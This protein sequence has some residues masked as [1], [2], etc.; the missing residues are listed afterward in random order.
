MLVECHHCGAPLDIRGSERFAKCKYCDHTNLV[1]S[2]KTVATQT[3]AQ[4]QPPQI[5]VPPAHLANH[6]KQVQVQLRYHEVTAVNLAD[7]AQAAKTASKVGC[8]VAAS[9]MVVVAVIAGAAV[10]AAMPSSIDDDQTPQFGAHSVAGSGRLDF[11][12]SAMGDVSAFNVGSSCRG[13]VSE[14][15]QLVLDVRQPMQ[16]RIDARGTGE[17]DAT[18]MMRGADGSI[19]CDDDSGG[20]RA[21]RI[22]T[23]VPPGRYRVWAGM[24]SMNSAEPYTLSVV[25]GAVQALPDARGVVA[26]GPPTGGTVDLATMPGGGRIE[27][28]TQPGVMV[29][30]WGSGCVGYVPVVPHL[31]VQAREPTPVAISAH[32]DGPGDLVLVVQDPQGTLHCNDDTDGRHPA[33]TFVAPPGVTAIWVGLLTQSHAQEQ[34][35]LEARSESLGGAARLANGLAPDAPPQM[36]VVEVR[37]NFAGVTMPGETRGTIRGQSVHGRC[38]GYFPAVPHVALQVG[39]RQR[40]RL[41]TSGTTDD[42]TMLVR[43]PGGDIRCDDDGGGGSQ[44]RLDLSLGPGAHH[45]WI[46]RYNEGAT[47][48]FSLRVLPR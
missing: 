6:F 16:L 19:R 40:V 47:V 38:R 22:D 3:P 36:G 17:G 39:R 8:I 14:A 41:E 20:D 5:W 7:A 28:T 25:Y 27:G 15:P 29:N 13:Y 2:M 21:A 35:T 23:A 43:D 31:H 33:V 4:W 30:T 46:G 34:F 45:V 48:S 26:A 12:G 32:T 11:V 37:R 9:V 44:P 10:Y 42:L 1:R 18:L 24:F